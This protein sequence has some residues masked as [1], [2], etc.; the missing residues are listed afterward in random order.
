M[1]SWQDRIELMTLPGPEQASS[2]FLGAKWTL[3]NLPNQSNTTRTD[4]MPG[5]LA[6]LNWSTTR[7]KAYRARDKHSRPWLGGAKQVLP[8]TLLFCWFFLEKIID[9]PGV[10]IKDA[11]SGKYFSV[12]FLSASLLSQSRFLMGFFELTL[13]PSR[14]L[15]LAIWVAVE[16]TV[17]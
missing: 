15:N 5:S 1:K 9:L 11:S 6:W 4:F 17:T 8:V 16:T 14:D 13:S 12:S 3:R 2:E 7:G 10:K